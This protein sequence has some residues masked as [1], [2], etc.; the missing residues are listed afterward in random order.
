MG[1]QRFHGVVVPR[2]LRLRHG[3]VDLVVADL[4]HEDGRPAL[5]AAQAR[6][7]VMQA[8]LGVW[9]DG[10]VAEGADGVVAHDG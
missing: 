3:G 5:A 6:D 1:T 10:P 9:R 4:V 2:K 8:L 7:Q